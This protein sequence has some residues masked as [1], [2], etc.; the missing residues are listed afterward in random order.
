MIL[1]DVYLLI[2]AFVSQIPY[3]VKAYKT[4]RLIYK[5]RI[6]MMEVSK[7]LEFIKFGV[8]LCVNEVMVLGW[9][10]T[11]YSAY[12]AIIIAALLHHPFWFG[13]LLTYFVYLST[14]LKKVL[15]AILKPI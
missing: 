11:I 6:E 3:L 7:P 4:T 10:V 12:L 13:I 5:E 8:N 15:D 14:I 2:I 1:L 9:D